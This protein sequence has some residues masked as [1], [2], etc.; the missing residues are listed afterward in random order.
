[1]DWIADP[2]GW[3]SLSILTLLEVVLG[4]DNIIFIAILV[5]RLPEEQRKS[6]RMLGLS[7]AM[8]T[9]ILLLFS[10]SFIMRL[11]SPFVSIL[12][13]SFSVRDLILILGGLFLIAKSTLEIH[14]KLEDHEQPAI[15]PKYGQYFGVLIQIA[16]LDIVFS[17]DSVITA[18]GMANE[19]AIM[20]IAVIAAV[21]FMMFFVHSISCFVERHPT[22][23]MLALS[24]LILIGVVLVGEGLSFHIP[25]G[26]IYFAMAYSMLVEMLNLR[27]RSKD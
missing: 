25:K 18:V 5:G 24:F 16:I 4:I 21:I 10:L 2:N 23:K 26:Y 9:R 27:M 15:A 13:F 11:T 7:L 12:D 14:R 3:I 20:V 19:L 8:L 17:F 22:I 6:A 1:M